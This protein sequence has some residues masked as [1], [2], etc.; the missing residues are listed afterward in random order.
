MS[1][2]HTKESISDNADTDQL[3]EDESPPE[4]FNN[5]IFES[6]YSP[7]S[8]NFQNLEQSQFLVTSPLLSPQPNF[9]S[10][11]SQLENPSDIQEITDPNSA[12]LL[13]TTGI[14]DLGAAFRESVE[15]FTTLESALSSHKQ[16]FLDLNYK[17]SQRDESIRHLKLDS[18]KSNETIGRL[19]GQKTELESR[20][21][22]LDFEYQVRGKEIE[23]MLFLLKA[24]KEEALELCDEKNILDN[25]LKALQEKYH[26][27]VDSLSN[28]TTTLKNLELDHEVLKNS[29]SELQI[30]YQSSSDEAKSQDI[31]MSL[32]IMELAKQSESLQKTLDEA[33]SISNKLQIQLEKTIEAHLE[34]KNQWNSEVLLLKTELELQNQQ[35]LTAIEEKNS[36]EEFRLSLENESKILTTKIGQINEENQT[37]KIYIEN[38]HNEQIALRHNLEASEVIILERDELQSKVKLMSTE[39]QELVRK[40]EEITNEISVIVDQNS[41]K[42]ATWSSERD[43]MINENSTL[44][45]Q[46]NDSKEICETLQKSFEDVTSQLNQNILLNSDKFKELQLEFNIAK[47]TISENTLIIEKLESELKIKEVRLQEE[48]EEKETYKVNL[49]ASDEEIQ[50]FKLQL[51]QMLA[52][53]SELESENLFINESKIDLASNYKHLQNEFSDKI[54]S[55]QH[56]N[57][58]LKNDLKIGIE[59]GR[60]VESLLKDALKKLKD[61][62]S[63]SEEFECELLNERSKKDEMLVSHNAMLDEK[64]LRIVE[65]TKLS[66]DKDSELKN[67]EKSLHALEELLNITNVGFELERQRLKELESI[68]KDEL[69]N[70][71]N[72][73]HENN[74]KILKFEKSEATTTEQLKEVMSELN[75]KRAEFSHSTNEI[76]R[77]SAEINNLERTLE[78]EESTKNELLLLYE[79]E[80]KL[81]KAKEDENQ[82]LLHLLS[83]EKIL[84]ELKVSDI[85][86]KASETNSFVNF[87]SNEVEVLKS[88]VCQI[89]GDRDAVVVEIENQS[90]KLVTLN[91]LLE[92]T[93]QELSIRCAE[94]GNLTNSLQDAESRIDELNAENSLL[95]LNIDDNLKELRLLSQKYV[96]GQNELN[97]QSDK[98]KMQLEVKITESEMMVVKIQEL[99]RNMDLTS[100]EHA[101]YK[102]NVDIERDYDK[103]KIHNLKKLLETTKDESAQMLSESKTKM[104]DLRASLD[105]NI[106]ETDNL[107]SIV[108]EKDREVVEFKL[109]ADKNSELLKEIKANYDTVKFNFESS[110]KQTKEL[111]SKIRDLESELTVLNEKATQITNDSKASHSQSSTKIEE[112]EST[113]KK[114]N[115]EKTQ[116]VE[117]GKFCE[118]ELKKEAL[119]YHNKLQ[120]VINEKTDQLNSALTKISVLE[121]KHQTLCDDLKTVKEQRNSAREKLSENIKELKQLNEE[122]ILERDGHETTRLTL[123]ETENKML[124]MFE[125]REQRVSKEISTQLQTEN[126]ESETIITPTQVHRSNIRRSARNVRFQEEITPK[127]DLAPSSNEKRKE[128]D[129]PNE[130]I[131]P[132]EKKFRQTLAD[133]AA[134]PAS[135]KKTREK[136]KYVITSTGLK[137]DEKN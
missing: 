92:Q 89:K 58:I 110:K 10:V 45:Q 55:L 108:F 125:E 61:A 114:L 80:K 130:L 21:Q 113:I 27:L 74:N 94:V 133:M 20:L 112:L 66:T 36:M 44:D 8:F 9:S 90:E 84:N 100:D 91:K 30:A 64:D 121:S 105:E 122:I 33:N 81:S 48:Q 40:L 102:S 56:E 73:I 4:S 87:L 129:T 128:T 19:T 127:Q 57:E 62:E 76:K 1:V 126:D 82:K 43:K 46:L 49:N 77:L 101:N 136:P 93:Q 16:F 67:N 103:Q 54:E 88:Q 11:S 71:E 83:E 26:V 52:R 75:L 59:E 14:S 109:E 18:S 131:T 60:N 119:S 28:T 79:E 5:E 39:K 65:L 31:S 124:I 116:I 104:N 38:Y 135:V 68:R 134:T 29:F 23:E 35:L 111:E 32:N 85:E 70:F 97:K 96:D 7:R 63:R 123:L 17:V 98:M 22:R 47:E 78:K 2:P 41:L 69:S 42:Q 118:E 95:R 115:T 13:L 12:F 86:L 34:E 15:K 117:N 51:E 3:N 106:K 25:D 6:N 132:P 137:P 50:S 99:E 53:I 37:L 72:Q 24:G 120:N 107:R